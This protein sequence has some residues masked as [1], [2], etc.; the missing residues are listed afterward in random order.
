MIEILQ[1]SYSS[2]ACK[3]FD[4]LKSMQLNVIL[5]R[6]SN[7][8]LEAIQINYS[9]NSKSWAWRRV[10]LSNNASFQRRLRNIDFKR[11]AKKCVSG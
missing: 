11:F 5:V 6:I 2:S 7:S 4:E 8:E 10:C 3:Y 1:R 9:I